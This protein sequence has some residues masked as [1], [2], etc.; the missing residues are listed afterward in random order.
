[1]WTW[2]SE[3]GCT[4]A[5]CTWVHLKGVLWGTVNATAVVHFRCEQIMDLSHY[6][7]VLIGQ[8]VYLCLFTHFSDT[9]NWNAQRQQKMT[10]S[11]F[12]WPFTLHSWQID[13]FTIQFWHFLKTKL[14][15]QSTKFKL[16]APKQQYP[17]GF[18]LSSGVGRRA[19][20]WIQQGNWTQCE[21]AWACVW[22][23]HLLIYFMSWTIVRLK[24]WS[25]QYM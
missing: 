10:L 24:L 14:H 20:N 4:S 2:L 23:K 6:N 8:T 18:V 11:S 19:V 15:F 16:E 7:H 13:A 3:L 22:K 21:A 9:H 12:I 5:I 1:M 17:I 25:T